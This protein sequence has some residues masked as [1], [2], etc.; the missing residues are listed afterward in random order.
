MLGLASRERT[1]VRTHLLG[2][3]QQVIRRPRRF[4]SAAARHVHQARLEDLIRYAVEG[5]FPQNETRGTFTPVFVDERGVECAVGHLL[6]RSGRGDLVER[7]AKTKN[8]ARIAELAD[9]PELVEWLDRVGLSCQEAG[10]IQP[11]YD[12]APAKPVSTC[13][14]ALFLRHELFVVGTMVVTPESNELVLQVDTWFGTAPAEGV[15]PQYLAYNNQAPHL[16][17]SY[18]DCYGGCLWLASGERVLAGVVDGV[19]Q[20]LYPVNGLP[21]M[22]SVD[23]SACA[24]S[25][26]PLYSGPWEV[27]LA[28]FSAVAEGASCVETFASKDGW[29]AWPGASCDN[30][31][32]SNSPA[33][34]DSAAGSG[35]SSGSGGSGGETSSGT[36]PGT[37]GADG[38]QTTTLSSGTSALYAALVAGLIIANGRSRRPPSVRRR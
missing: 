22:E 18:G 26:E 7:I 16:Q 6:S 23:V 4:K 27:E 28:A 11:C 31:G 5:I 37:R 2:A 33:G 19:L 3:I 14:C 13:A 17:S 38:C 10:R 24:V 36:D 32:G 30:G 9:E 29:A 34:S 1:R 12:C 8:L 25:C 15:P 35:G 20:L 21:G